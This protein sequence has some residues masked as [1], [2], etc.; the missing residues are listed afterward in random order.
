M[1]RSTL[2]PRPKSPTPTLRTRGARGA[3]KRH[4]G[5]PDYS[6]RIKSARSRLAPQFSWDDASQRYR[7]R[8]TGRFVPNATIRNA[9]DG[10][11]AN[12]AAEAQ[13]LTDAL[14]QGFLSREEWTRG[15][16]RNVK[17]NHLA[18]TALAN[19]GWGKL[20]PADY[21]RLGSRVKEQYRYLRRFAQEIET[22][23]QALDGRAV[24]R[25]RMY[26]G[27]ARAAYQEERRRRHREQGKTQERRI[28]TA[29]E[30]CAD[31]IEYE[32]RGW[33]PIGTLPEIGRSKCL[34]NCK[35]YFEFRDE[36]S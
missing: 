30:S 22:E 6:T 34:T 18:A 11:L 13:R 4:P 10:Y 15:M 24:V 20:T 8:A 28:R 14:R 36:V 5:M 2:T 16:M 12:G 17:N 7:N 9:L 3:G 1:T 26:A 21:G 19:G 23:Q 29:S 27:A 35:C 25:A 33:A 32:Q 31:C